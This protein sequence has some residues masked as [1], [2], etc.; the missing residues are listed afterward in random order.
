M[1]ENVVLSPILQQCLN[2]LDRMQQTLKQKD[3]PALLPLAESYAA[4]VKQ[5]EDSDDRG[6]IAELLN[7]HEGVEASLAQ[8]LKENDAMLHQIVQD[9]ISHAYQ[10]A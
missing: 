4:F 1:K 8:S 5:L 7:A 10:T 2:L 6:S 9:K 3:I